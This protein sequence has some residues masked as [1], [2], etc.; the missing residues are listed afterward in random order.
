M[1][2]RYPYLLS[3]LGTKSCHTLIY[4]YHENNV[5]PTIY[6]G[7]QHRLHQRVVGFDQDIVSSKAVELEGEMHNL[8]MGIT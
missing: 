7:I 4:P 1:A 6:Y 5:F 8:E 3:Y 2:L